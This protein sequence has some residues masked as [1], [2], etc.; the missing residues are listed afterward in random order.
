MIGTQKETRAPAPRCFALLSFV[1]LVLALSL[2]SVAAN[3]APQGLKASEGKTPCRITGINL[4]TGVVTASV[5][6]GGT[7]TLKPSSGGQSFRFF[8]KDSALL[9]SLKEGLQVIIDFNTQQVFTIAGAS[10][11]GVRLGDLLTGNDAK[12]GGGAA[13]GVNQQPNKIGEPVGPIDGGRPVG[14]IDGARPVGPIDGG[15]PVGPID[16]ARPVGPIDGANLGNAANPRQANCQILSLNAATG[17]VRAKNLSNG[18]FFQFTVKDSALFRSFNVGQRFF[19][20]FSSRQVSLDG[21]AFT[22]VQSF[23]GSLPN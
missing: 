20:N 9:N 12:I 10:G 2:G 15:R 18:Q 6:D 8:V 19:F 4:K 5:I 16:G 23:G 17:L 1:V 13:G 21:K 14:P 3:A 11:Q 7:T 22:G